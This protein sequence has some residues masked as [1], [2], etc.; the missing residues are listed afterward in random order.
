MRSSPLFISLILLLAVI[1]FGSDSHAGACSGRANSLEAFDSCMVQVRGSVMTAQVRPASA[2]S[3]DPSH[4]ALLSRMARTQVVPPHRV[5]PTIP[6]GMLA[7]SAIANSYGRNNGNYN[8][9][10]NWWVMNSMQRI[11]Y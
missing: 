7:A 2:S 9:Y 1:L 8:P 4:R 3:T 11:S 6:F 5:S 10:W